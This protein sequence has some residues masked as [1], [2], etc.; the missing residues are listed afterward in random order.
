M[1]N[2][3]IA[4]VSQSFYVPSVVAQQLQPEITYLFQDY[5]LKEDDDSAIFVAMVPL[6][7]TVPV[8]TKYVRCIIFPKI[9]ATVQM[10][11][12]GSLVDG[13]TDDTFRSVVTDPTGFVLMPNYGTPNSYATTTIYSSFFML[14]GVWSDNKSLFDAMLLKANAIDVPT[15]VHGTPVKM[16]GSLT[17]TAANA[18]ATC[19]GF[20]YVSASTQDRTLTVAAGI[21]L[22][23]NWWAEIGKL[24]TGVGNLVLAT[25][26]G[27]VLNSKGGGRTMS[28]FNTFGKIRQTATQDSF[29]VMAS[30]ITA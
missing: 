3:V 27:A 23:L 9:G 15:L 10:H 7:F 17:I 8:L 19:G 16:A 12:V 28:V 2:A 5:T 29:V 4:L 26:G 30:D 14:G 20:F 21:P 18:A 22:A 6:I 11:Q 24:A 13:R 25:S 1:A